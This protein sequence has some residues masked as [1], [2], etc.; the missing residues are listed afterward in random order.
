MPAPAPSLVDV[1]AQTL[2]GLRDAIDRHDA[3]KAASFFADDCWVASYAGPDLHGREEV[4]A[5]LQ[6]MFDAFGDLKSAPL[7]RWVKGNVVAYEFAWAGTM[8][9]DFMGVK[10]SHK[11]A[12]L[13]EFRVVR[14]G[15]DGLIKEMHQYADMAGLVA[16]MTGKKTAPPVPILPSNVLEPHVAKGTSEEDELAAWAKGL[17]ETRSKGNPKAVLAAMADDADYWNN[18]DGP[19]LKGKRELEKGVTAWFK[20]FPDQKW[21]VT[22]AW[23]IDGFAIVEHSMS[24]TQQGSLGALAASKK[25]VSDWHWVDV[26]QPVPASSGSS[27]G[28]PAPSGELLVQHGWGFA[29]VTEMTQQTG[30]LKQ[31]ADK[32]TTKAAPGSTPVKVG[33]AP[34]KK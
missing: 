16:Q 15:A 34:K 27:A 30:A 21:T 2:A 6:S 29:N 31:P 19:S 5:E 10:A 28:A 14:S 23:G 7:R 11:P 32:T 18:L 24:G 17:D 8:S 20:A 3:K 25:A 12:G 9:G 26:L 4:A 1:V 33:P 22:G 13:V